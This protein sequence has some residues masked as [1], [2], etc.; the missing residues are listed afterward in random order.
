M[1]SNEYY[2]YVRYIVRVVVGV[3]G[4]AG[5]PERYVF[6]VHVSLL[7]FETGRVNYK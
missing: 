1:K 2:V 6:R 3:V 4:R 7:E 5:L